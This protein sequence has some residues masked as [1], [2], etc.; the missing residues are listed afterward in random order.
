MQKNKFLLLIMASFSQCNRSN[1]LKPGFSTGWNRNPK[2]DWHWMSSHPQMQLNS[3]FLTK[4]LL[5]FRIPQIHAKHNEAVHSIPALRGSTP[6]QS[7]ILHIPTSCLN[8]KPKCS[9][10]NNKWS[11]SVTWE[12]RTSSS[13]QFMWM[14][15]MAMTLKWILYGL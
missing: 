7:S 11:V 13:P 1:A 4:Q 10:I 14:E 5:S 15:D 8:L 9:K 3:I 2:Y 12:T 6:W